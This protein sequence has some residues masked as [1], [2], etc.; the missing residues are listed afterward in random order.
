MI[1]RCCIIGLFLFALLGMSEARATDPAV[2]YANKVRTDEIAYKEGYF[3]EGDNRL[4]YVDA[5]EGPLIILYHGFPSFWFS[6][7]DQMEMLKTRYRVVAVDGLGAGLSAKPEAAEP[8]RIDRLAAQLDALAKHLNGDERFILIGHDWGAALAFAYAQAYP[9]RLNAVIG[10]SAPPYNLFLDLVRTNKEQQ[11]RSQYMQVFRGL[12]L[13]SIAS[14]GLPE[15]IWQQSYGGLLQS[16]ELSAEEGALFRAA[17]ADPRAIHGGMN[18]YRANVQD[19]ADAGKAFRWPATK[20]KIRVPSLLIWGDA[21][22]TFVEAFLTQI[23]KYAPGISIAR[24]PGV[25]HWTPMENPTLA[26]EA[27]SAFLNA[28]EKAPNRR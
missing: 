16:G 19:F 20:R 9:K 14:S 6:F 24:Q 25:G 4:H 1:S 3:G 15:R 2:V 27:I 7:F 23:D 13:A 12:T 22:K 21:D 10:M 8:Y 18:W 5:G 28:I 11:Q 26:N 17:L